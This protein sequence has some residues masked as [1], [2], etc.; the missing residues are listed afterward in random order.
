[1]DVLKET[2]DLEKLGY[3]IENIDCFFGKE[4]EQDIKATKE[5]TKKFLEE[6][7][8]NGGE[9]SYNYN[10][11]RY[12]NYG[13]KYSHGIQGVC[14]KMR[15]YLL[16]GSGVV[17]YD[18]K[19][20]HPTILWSLCVKHKIHTEKQLLKSYVFNRDEV[21]QEHFQ[22]EIYNEEDVKKL[23]LTATNCDD[24]LF[25][26]NT[27]LVD[28]QNEMIFIREQLHKVKDY[29]KIS[30]DTDKL[31]QDSR[32]INSSFVNRILCKVE[33][34]IIDKITT[35]IMKN[36]YEVFS[37]MFDGLMVYDGTE[38]LLEMIN[39]VV[40]TAY[41]DYFCITQKDITTDVDDSGYIL[42]LD[43][44][45]GEID[46]VETRMKRFIDKF[47]PIK[48][49]NPPLYGIKSAEGE[50]S[51][52][53]KDAFIQATE[54][55]KYTNEKNQQASVVNKWLNDYIGDEDIYDSI[56]TDPEY[57]GTDNFNLWTDWDVNSWQ[58]EWTYDEKAVEYWRHHILVMCNY[59]EAVA[60]SIEN[61]IAH[62]FKYPKNK[63]FVPI[64]VG[65]Q[66]TGKDM[67]IA[68]ITKLLG[69]KKKF[70]TSTPEKNV[71][72]QFNPFMK[73]AYLIHLSEFGR[74][75]TQDYVGSIKAISTT[76]TIMI[77][78]KNKGEYEINS[79]HRFVGASNYGEPLP[80]E[81]DNRRFLLI[82][83]SAD[84]IGDTEYFNEGWGYIKNKNAMKSVYDYLMQMD[85]PEQLQ[86]HMIAES[87]YTQYLK[88]ISKPQEEEFLRDFVSDYTKLG[89]VD[90]FRTVDV[91][92]K[93]VEWCAE[94]L[95]SFKMEKRKFLVQFKTV[96]CNTTAHIK[97]KKINGGNM[98]AIFD[99]DGLRVEGVYMKKEEEECDEIGGVCSGDE[100]G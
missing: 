36:K 97:I 69:Q 67:L 9:M 33:G 47:K 75:N 78:E 64:F 83:T 96:I 58:A 52:H 16:S 54:H 66:G 74:R 25:T 65:K 12:T 51:F 48:I 21:I 29:K 70:E 76:G 87:E 93:Y 79:Y 77:N 41:G 55:I 88:G 18:I 95:Q 45:L 26:N 1:M 42:D 35:F 40:K 14:K 31:K 5:K 20:A 8:I 53:K 94:T 71:W 30:Q 23:I 15:N 60:H 57:A 90:K 6:L 49:I 50:Y 82:L 38:E 100:E 24:L 11:A 27:W 43:K 91:Y 7:I 19:N 92:R 4:T 3:A 59:D 34:E 85:V 86:Y 89:K 37:L 13:R 81:S 10:Y 17:D 68:M 22:E 99:W 84:K 62:M 73:S 80:I 28:Y 44:L 61:W 39:Q 56:I 72:G 32:N 2:Y 63:S 98:Y 46:N